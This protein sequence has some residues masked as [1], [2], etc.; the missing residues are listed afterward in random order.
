MFFLN[1]KHGL[2]SFRQPDLFRSGDIARGCRQLHLFSLKSFFIPG[3]HS[4]VCFDT[5]V[6]C[7]ISHIFS[8]IFFFSQQLFNEATEPL[9]GQVEYR[10]TYT[11]MSKQEV[12]LPDKTKVRLATT[13]PGPSCLKLTTSLVND[14]LKFT[15]SDTQIC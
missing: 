13:L 15:S 14:S 3:L 12:V 4:S 2:K 9:S 10:H 6:W 8:L 11:D 1:I 5:I 7:D